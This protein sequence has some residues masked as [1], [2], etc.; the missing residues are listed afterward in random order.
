MAH[1]PPSPPT[2]GRVLLVADWNVDPRAI[3]GAA[4]RRAERGQAAFGLVVPAWLHGVEW[5]GDPTASV[6]CALRQMVAISSLADD[7]G[8]QLATAIVGDPDPATAVVDAIQCWP[9][10]EVLLCVRGR[11]L[12]AGRLDL[13]HRVERMTG[14][15]VQRAVVPPAARRRA[16]PF[17]LH[18]R[19]GR[20]TLEPA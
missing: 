18:V 2:P 1:Q 11:R 16:R 14:L 17:R 10:G 5:V 7:A 9:A 8:L 13:A 3:V 19:R 12:T 15:P 6:P 4:C 20:C